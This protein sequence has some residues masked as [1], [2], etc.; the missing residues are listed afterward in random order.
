MENKAI[1]HTISLKIIYQK[2][3]DNIKQSRIRLSIIP[4]AVCECR[5]KEKDKIIF[6]RETEIEHRKDGMGYWG[7]RARQGH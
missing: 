3:I 7:K 5:L 6:R 1:K 2:G 4:R